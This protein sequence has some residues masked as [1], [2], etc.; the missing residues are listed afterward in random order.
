MRIRI[1]QILD[2]IYMPP[3][4]QIHVIVFATKLQLVNDLLMYPGKLTV[5][6]QFLIH[7]RTALSVLQLIRQLLNMYKTRPTRNDPSVMTLISR[8]LI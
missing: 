5:P 6:E 1:R 4:Y 2:F 3:F 8:V 7:V